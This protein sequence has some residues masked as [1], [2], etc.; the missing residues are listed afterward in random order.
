MEPLAP[1]VEMVA[2]ELIKVTVQFTKL[3]EEL[4]EMGMTRVAIKMG[5]NP[6]F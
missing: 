5:E 1:N 6:P 4:H 3:L 2:V